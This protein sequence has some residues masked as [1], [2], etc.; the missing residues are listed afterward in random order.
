MER[1]E[2]DPEVVD[3]NLRVLSELYELGIALKS[4]R[5]LGSVESLPKGSEDAAA[6][7]TSDKGGG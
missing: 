5:I 2:L 7:Q 3:R 6:S 4:V 1:N